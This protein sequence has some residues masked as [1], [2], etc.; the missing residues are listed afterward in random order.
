MFFLGFLFVLIFFFLFPSII[1]ISNTTVFCSRDQ[2]MVMVV[3]SLQEKLFSCTC[4]MML[5]F[6][7]ICEKMWHRIG[8]MWG[9]RRV[10][11]NRRKLNL[12][13][14]DRTLNVGYVNP[15][16]TKKLFPFPKM[17]QPLGH[18]SELALVTAASRE[19]QKKIKDLTKFGVTNPTTIC[20]HSCMQTTQESAM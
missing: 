9:N 1:G 5:M 20:M 11:R 4:M 16:V 19:L 3:V 13:V 6:F 2:I 8:G 14:I 7:R 10:G 15:F 12:F 18:P 17:I